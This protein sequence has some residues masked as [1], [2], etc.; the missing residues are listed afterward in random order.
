MPRTIS[1]Q[2]DKLTGGTLLFFDDVLMKDVQN[3]TIS[4]HVDD[5]VPT[6]NVEFAIVNKQ[7]Y[8]YPTKDELDQI[9]QSVIKNKEQQDEFPNET[10]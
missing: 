1:I 6:I 5:T 7:G 3:F 2:N 9:A 4:C 10:I 8:I